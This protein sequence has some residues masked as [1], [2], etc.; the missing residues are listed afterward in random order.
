MGAFEYLSVLLSIVLGLGITHLLLGFGRWLEQRDTFQAYEPALAWAAFLLLVHVQ[1]W[2]T[3]FGYQGFEDWNFLQ[4]SVVLL[5]PIL[6]FL[7]AVV[8][9]PGPNAGRPDLR[10]NFLHQRPW[11]YGL[12]AAL[13]VVSLLKDLVRDGHLPETPNLVFHGVFL[14]G[15]VIGWHSRRESVHRLLAYLGLLLFF[16]YIAVLFGDL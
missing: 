1:T 8:V 5:Q 11:F 14:A 16:G 4:F 7:L 9:F 13:L 15:A 2:W 10:E 6:L 12:L 3:M